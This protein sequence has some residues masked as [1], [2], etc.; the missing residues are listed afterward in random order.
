MMTNATAARVISET[1]TT[2]DF[3]PQPRYVPVVKWIIGIAILTYVFVRAFVLDPTGDEVVGRLPYLDQLTI[4]DRPVEQAQLP[5][6]LLGTFG[7]DVLPFEP[8]VSGRLF[9]ALLVV[10]FLYSAGRVTRIIPSPMLQ[11]LGFMTLTFNVYA[12][13]W[14]SLNRGYA[15]AYAF[16]MTSLC[17]MGEIVIQDRTKPIPKFKMF[18]A[19]WAAAAAATC[20][21][22]FLHFFVAFSIVVFL[23]IVNPVNMIKTCR[24]GSSLLAQLTRVIVESQYLLFAAAVLGVHVIPRFLI[25]KTGNQLYSGGT[26]GFIHDSVGTVLSNSLYRIRLSAVTIDVLA[27]IVA[28][29]AIA[30]GV[31]CFFRKDSSNAQRISLLFFAVQIVLF[32]V[33]YF[34][35]LMVDLLFIW[36]RGALA[37]ALLFAGQLCFFTASVS[38]NV[39]KS[40]FVSVSTIY[41]AIALYGANFDYVLEQRML[42][43]QRKMLRDLEAIYEKT[44]TPVVLGCSD[45]VKLKVNYFKN[46]WAL[47]WLTFYSIDMYV[48]FNRPYQIRPDSTHFYIWS[49]D[50]VF[51]AG[52]RGLPI[53]EVPDLDYPFTDCELYQI[54]PGVTLSDYL[55]VS[56]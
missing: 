20:H 9:N 27:W 15:P 56:N 5:S 7:M 41:V 43:K 31:Y 17:F 40:I 14:F 47:D 36:H 12:L 55:T 49:R 37:L 8:F 10:L 25:L 29:M 52:L 35:H 24:S 50:G 28:M 54:K 13:D 38:G 44:N 53:Q 6:F 33:V 30:M 48:R 46:K 42:S 32:A 26:V 51:P 45:T 22:A 19:T 2:P 3:P 34:L 4:C 16:A 39:L 23:W 1:A 21:F 18:V 11:I